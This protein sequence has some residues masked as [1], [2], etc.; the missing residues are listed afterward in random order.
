SGRGW[1]ARGEEIGRSARSGTVCPSLFGPA[2]GTVC[3]LGGRGVDRCDAL[4]TPPQGTPLSVRTVGCVPVVEQDGT[5]TGRMSCELGLSID[6]RVADG[7]DAARALQE[8]QDLLDDP[9]RLAL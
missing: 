8:I 9:L 3:N 6:H 5:V 1:C 7:A 4:L 2:T